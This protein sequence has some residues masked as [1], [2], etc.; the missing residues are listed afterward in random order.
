MGKEGTSWF[1]GLD[2][3]VNMWI[4]SET[5]LTDKFLYEWIKVLLKLLFIRGPTIR[6]RQTQ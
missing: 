6:F 1:L 3:N 2:R 5:G 4:N